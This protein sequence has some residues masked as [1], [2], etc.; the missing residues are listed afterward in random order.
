MGN[1]NFDLPI[2]VQ[3]QLHRDAKE[4][5]GE[6]DYKLKDG[7]HFQQI[8]GQYSF[9]R[10]IEE[11]EESLKSYYQQ[12]F[13][14]PLICGGEGDQRYYFLDFNGT[15][16]GE[17]DGEHRYHIRNEYIII[18]FLIYKVIYIDQNLEL[19]SV[20]LLQE[21]IRKDYEELKGDLYRLI[22]KA[23]KEN[24]SQMNDKSMDD[25]VMKALKEFNKI[26][27]ISLDGDTFDPNPALNRLHKMYSDYINDI[28]TYIK[29]L[30]EQ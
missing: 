4:L 30:S 11:N 7:M 28:D 5:F 27:W 26:G 20:R 16:R 25:T 6:L 24:P 13:G 17:I 1:E 2:A 15:N 19:S 8:D 22:A 10:F 18:G 23:K 12:F 29:K 21:T 3:F 14:V 9:F